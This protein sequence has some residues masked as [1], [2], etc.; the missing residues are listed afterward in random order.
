MANEYEIFIKSLDIEYA[1]YETMSY[2]NFPIYG[3]FINEGFDE[4]G[5]RSRFKTD[6]AGL[7]T[8]SYEHYR[9]ILEKCFNSTKDQLMRLKRESHF[10]ASSS[11]DDP[12]AR[13]YWVIQDSIYYNLSILNPQ[14]H[15][16]NLM[17]IEFFENKKETNEYDCLHREIFNYHSIP[18]HPDFKRQLLEYDYKYLDEVE[19]SPIFTMFLYPITLTKFGKTNILSVID[20]FK[21]K[22]NDFFIKNNISLLRNFLSQYKECNISELSEM[23][24]LKENIALILRETEKNFT[25]NK[26]PKIGKLGGIEKAINHKLSSHAE[27]ELFNIIKKSF[28]LLVVIQHGKP[29]FL[30]KQHYDIWIP[31]LKIAIEYQG[32]QHS[33]SIKY[34]GGED[35]LKAQTERD[36][37]KHDISINNGITLIYAS[38]GYNYIEIIKQ[39]K[40]KDNAG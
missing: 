28:P 29:D 22:L 37:R 15:K 6:Y 24:L 32:E 26:F 17:F 5:Y 14:M 8:S 31:K 33:K 9:N 40:I 35:G 7:L 4:S 39:I 11:Y 34:F 10:G 12:F 27:T 25:D 20:I 38:K 3:W 23:K 1:K 30:E 16:I 18:I 36:K 13:M 19:F 2:E 21:E